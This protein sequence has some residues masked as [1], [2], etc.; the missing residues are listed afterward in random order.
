MVVITHHLIWQRSFFN[1]EVI[2]D[3]R[4]DLTEPMTHVF[5][6]RSILFASPSLS[7]VW[8]S[9]SVPCWRIWSCWD[10][11]ISPSELRQL[12]GRGSFPSSRSEEEPDLAFWNS[13]FFLLNVLSSHVILSAAHIST[14][15]QVSWKFL[16]Q[17][18]PYFCPLDNAECSDVYQ[19]YL[20]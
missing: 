17:V 4:V 6:A 15:S 7:P 20:N 8:V 2:P 9:K 3:S 19:F 11:G 10:A 12:S 5:P 16:F 1:I 18:Y 14:F 13:F